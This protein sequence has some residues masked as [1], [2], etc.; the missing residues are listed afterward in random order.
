MK[1][2]VTCDGSYTRRDVIGR[3]GAVVVVAAFS[4]D[5]SQLS[6]Q[7]RGL[8]DFLGSK[9]GDQRDVGGA[10]LCWCPPG[11]FRMGSASNEP[12]RHA[13]EQQTDVTLTRGFWIGKYSVTQGQWKEVMGALPGALSAGA[14]DDFPVYNVNY[15]EAE[16]FCRTFTT[17]QR[18]SGALPAGWEFRLPTEAQWEYACRAGTAVATAFGD[19]LSSRQANFDGNFPYNGAEKGPTLGRAAKVGSYAANPWGIYDMHGNI[20]DWCRDW[21]HPRLPGGTDPDRSSAEASAQ[22]NRDGTVSR[23]RRGGCWADKGWPCRSACRARFEPE[24]RADHIGFRILAVQ[25]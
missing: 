7:P 18:T 19:R 23:V 25:L 8:G 13:D 20:F 12:E 24:R 17:R 21:Y 9:G 16:T 2:N 10:P 5:S 3:V 11:R 22:R 15:A 6:G 4:G 1:Q 14:G